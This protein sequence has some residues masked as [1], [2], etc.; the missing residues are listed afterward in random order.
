MDR[1]LE[2]I[3]A[4]NRQGT[5]VFLVEQNTS[6][7]LGIAH[8]AYVLQTGRIVS[9]DDGFGL[10][11]RHPGSFPDAE[12]MRPFGPAAS[13]S[14]ATVP[15]DIPGSGPGAIRLAEGS[16]TRYSWRTPR[17]IPAACSTSRSLNSPRLLTTYLR[18]SGSGPGGKQQQSYVVLIIYILWR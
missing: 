13:V 14:H 8:R 10:V 3:A 9:P 4:I 6:L 11:E 15:G 12:G 18:R 7:A 2:L 5:A 17:T 16:S 1:V